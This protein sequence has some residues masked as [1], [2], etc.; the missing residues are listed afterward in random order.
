MAAIKRALLPLILKTV[1]LPTL[2]AFGKVCL[3]S[4]NEL[5]LVCLLIRY[6]DS[7][8]AEQSGCFLANSSK[9]F[10][11]MMCIGGYYLIMRYLSI[12]KY[13]AKLS[14]APMSLPRQRRRSST[15]PLKRLVRRLRQEILFC[16]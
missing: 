5:K 10:R 15:H 13:N 11:V 6:Q 2:S 3:S 14:G 1:K 12:K 7:S 9:R 8:E 4:V 16:L